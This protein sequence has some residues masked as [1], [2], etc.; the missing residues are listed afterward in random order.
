MPIVRGAVCP[1]CHQ[2][3]KP[4]SGELRACMCQ[5]TL[6]WITA[7]GESAASGPDGLEFVEVIAPYRE[8]MRLPL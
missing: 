8:Q 5:K 2:L 1:S 7:T 6:A 3:V 4:V